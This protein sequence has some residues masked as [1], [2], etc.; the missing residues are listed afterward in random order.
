M[1]LQS[2]MRDHWHVSVPLS[3]QGE[4]SKSMTFSH[5]REIIP[6]CVCGVRNQLR[7]P[8]YRALTLL[9]FFWLWSITKII[10]CL[11]PFRQKS[12]QRSFIR[13]NPDIEGQIETMILILCKNKLVRASSL[14]Q[15]PATLK[16]KTHNSKCVASI[17]L[18]M[19]LADSWSILC[20]LWIWSLHVLFKHLSCLWVTIL[21]VY[22]AHCK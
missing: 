4:E 21:S 15:I 7:A 19:M 6:R 8:Q 12:C 18:E 17:K 22:L 3:I 9:S 13:E 2:F 10:N 1:C 16:G 20:W 11:I 14:I 5:Q